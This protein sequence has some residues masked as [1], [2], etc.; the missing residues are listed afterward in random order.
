MRNGRYILVICLLLA[1]F[2]AAEALAADS[3][4]ARAA[5]PHYD[6]ASLR[7]IGKGSYRSEKRHAQMRVTVCLRKKTAGRFFDVRCET[8]TASGKRA[9]AEVSVPGCVKGIWRTS[10]VGE[11]LG[12][13]GAL[14]NQSSAVS[15]PFRC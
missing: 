12:R 2:A 9:N 13:G 1:G 6:G 15:K 14:L 7:L 3:Y 8:A 11:A 10:T 5:R 4:S